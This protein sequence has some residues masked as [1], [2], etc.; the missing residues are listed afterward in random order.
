MKRFKLLLIGVITGMLLLSVSACSQK[1]EKKSSEPKNSVD[2][3]QPDAKTKTDTGASDQDQAQ[4]SAPPIKEAKN[5][6]K[7]DSLA[8]QK[9]MDKYF[10]AFNSEDID[11]Y[12]SIIS[13][14]PKSFDYDSEKKYTKN[15][16]DHMDVR[17]NPKSIIIMDYDKKKQE[18][19]VFSEIET[20][21]TD[22]QTGQSAKSLTRQIN[23]FHK[24]DGG[25]KIIAT[26]VMQDK[27]GNG[28]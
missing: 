24:E 25:W 16:F 22:P 20:T 15:T 7:E 26:S 1:D 11:A 4:T 13:K 28:K 2:Q 9:V 3:N 23:T 21:V 27:S 8:L 6:S 14:H 17:L 10:Q 12:M 5:I 19:N 18:A